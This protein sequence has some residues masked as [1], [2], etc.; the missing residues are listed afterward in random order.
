M[1]VSAGGLAGQSREGKYMFCLRQ[2]WCG[3]CGRCGHCLQSL[4]SS[5]GSTDVPSGHFFRLHVLDFC[6]LSYYIVVLCHDTFYFA[7]SYRIAVYE[8]VLAKYRIV[9]SFSFVLFPKFLLGCRTTGSAP[10][11]T[12]HIDA[13]IS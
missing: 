6:N 7:L 9:N 11:Y 3:R 1:E 10:Q 5:K 4:Y 12:T 8:Y 13:D 2:C